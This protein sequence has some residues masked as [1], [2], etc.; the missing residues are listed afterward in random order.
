MNT[1]QASTNYLNAIKTSNK[2][3]EDFVPDYSTVVRPLMYSMGLNAV[4]QNAQAITNLTGI[5]E[6]DPTGFLSNERRVSDITGMRNDLRVFSK[7]LGMEMR[8]GGLFTYT[9]TAM[10]NAMKAMERA[11]YANDKKA[12]KDA[13]R[14]A[15]SLSDSSD[16]RKDIITKFKQRHI[17]YNI[18]RFAL[19]DADLAGM[20]SVMDE[21]NRKAIRMAIRNHEY[22]LRSIGGVPT[23]RNNNTRQYE[24]KLRRLA[25]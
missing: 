1:V 16:P 22:Y 8:S 12:F 19:S 18:T 13:Y 20:L 4:I 25:L 23:G 24:E 11:A 15:I 7:V 10:G 5:E 9:A 2:E 21:D 14:K 6:Y 3:L 17:R